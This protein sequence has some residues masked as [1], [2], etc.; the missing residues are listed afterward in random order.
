MIE[1]AAKTD[2]RDAAK[3]FIDEW[4]TMGRKAPTLGLLMDLLIKA[5]L[6]RIA[7]C[8]ACDILNRKIYYHIIYINFIY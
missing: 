3:I 2:S 6:F 1:E 5:E 4:S 7:D 8:I